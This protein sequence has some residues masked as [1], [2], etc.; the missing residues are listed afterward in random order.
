MQ[1]IIISS[2][3]FV[4]LVGVIISMWNNLS[5]GN[6]IVPWNSKYMPMKGDN[7]IFLF[8][9]VDAGAQAVADRIVALSRKNKPIYLIIDSPGGSI[10]H[11]GAIVAALETSAV[12]VY[13]VCLRLCASMAAI[14]HSYGTFRYMFP[15]SVLM[16]HPAS[17]GF[18]G[19]FNQIESRY[20]F[21][22]RYM[23]KFEIDVAKRAN[24]SISEFNRY[25]NSEFWMDAD[26]AVKYKFADKIIINEG[27]LNE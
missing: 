23:E 6:S 2:V 24:M 12:P 11:G 17:G 1:K 16:Y 19:D 21:F 15:R 25:R 27:A 13:T 3:G 9:E 26:D 22:K 18:Q 20:N 14:I 4:F 8:G 10:I 7:K 5:E